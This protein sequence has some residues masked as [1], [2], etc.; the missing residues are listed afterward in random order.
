MPVIAGELRWSYGYTWTLQ[1]V[2]GTRAPLKR[3]HALAELTLSGSADPL[4]ALAGTYRGCDRR[5]LLNHAWRLLLQSEFHDSIGGCTS[6]QVARRVSLRLQDARNLAAEIARTS[7]D[8][9]VGNNPDRVRDQPELGEPQL[10]LW[11]PV[12]RPRSGVVIADV[13]WFERDVLVGPPG[14]NVPRTGTGARPFHFVGSD[15]PLGVQ[16]LGRRRDYERLDAARHYPDQDEVD[17]TRVAFE[18]QAVKGMGFEVYGLGAG[19]KPVQGGAWLR[20]RS[21]GNEL[22]EIRIGGGGN[23]YPERSSYGPAVP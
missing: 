18:T 15:A 3:L 1:G 17:C 2:H 16:W 12:P 23:H 11:N 22:L 19:A 13:T 8:E 14:D 20:G 9:L 4:A 10:V 6:D 5:P 7:L 21:M